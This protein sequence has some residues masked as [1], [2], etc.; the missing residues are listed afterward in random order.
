VSAA[1]EVCHKLAEELSHHEPSPQ[2]GDED[3]LLG[4]PL[5]AA[6][7]EEGWS[8]MTRW[9]MTL[10]RQQEHESWQEIVKHTDQRARELIDRHHLSDD[11]RFERTKCF[12]EIASRVAALLER[13]YAAHAFPH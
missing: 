12:G 3:H 10:A 2:D 5:K 8:V 11:T 13:D 1:R 7:D 9:I 4:A 6:F